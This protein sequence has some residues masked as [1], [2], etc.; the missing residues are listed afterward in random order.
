[1]QEKIWMDLINSSNSIINNFSSDQKVIIETVKNFSDNLVLFSQIYLSDRESFFRFLK[2]KYN[3]F[4]LQ[5]TSIISS[6]DSVSVI[7]QLN[8]GV[9]DY[10]IYLDSY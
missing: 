6:A 9:K 10:L 8:E 3:Y 2:G 1:M 4:Y 5:A 7:M